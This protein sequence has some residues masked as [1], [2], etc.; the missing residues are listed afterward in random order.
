MRPER[1]R[2]D[3]DDPVLGA[4]GN[5][6]H[7]DPGEDPIFVASL[8]PVAFSHS[9]HDATI[10]DAALAMALR[11]ERFE[12]LHPG[13]RTPVKV[14]HWSGLRAET[15]SRQWPEINGS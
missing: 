14:A 3:Y 6:T 11:K 1:G 4:F 10:I 13:V 7:H 2:I 8:E 5:Q 15:E 12:A 9:P